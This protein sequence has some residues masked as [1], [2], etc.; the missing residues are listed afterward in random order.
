MDHPYQLENA[1]PAQAAQQRHG[2]IDDEPGPCLGCI[3]APRCAALR[4]ACTVF[5]G[6]VNGDDAPRWSTERRVP[7]R[8]E[9]L[10]IFGRQSRPKAAK[11]RRPPGQPS[12]A[13]LMRSWVLDSD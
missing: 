2:T 5:H 1:P 13:G 9:F 7:S 3:E 11:H 12:S 4:L 6:F 8:V 10:A